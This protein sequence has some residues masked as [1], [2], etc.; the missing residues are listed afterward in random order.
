M[1]TKKDW[2]SLKNGDI[3]DLIKIAME[4]R[5]NSIQCPPKEKIWNN[6]LVDIR[7]NRR[8]RKLQNL[9]SLVAVVAIMLCLSILSISYHV[10]VFAFAD[11]IFKSIIEITENSFRIHKGINEAD[12]LAIN[13]DSTGSSSNEF[14]DPRI[15]EAKSKVHFNLAIPR[16]LPEGYSLKKVDVLNENENKETV[17]FQYISTEK[18]ETSDF[19][20]IV[21]E[22]NSEDFNC[23]LTVLRE[24]GTEMKQVIVEDIEYTL[25]IYNNELVKVIWDRDYINYKIDAN[26][27][28]DETIKIAQSMK[29]E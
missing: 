12:K 20:S 10:P 21:Q 8:K 18:D 1:S 2:K 22:S 13:G 25:F 4:V 5:Y 6:I 24:E 17:S 3:D 23:T 14:N 15:F 19:I 11:K 26:I 7:K 28:E 27:G 9:K 16:Y 29:Q